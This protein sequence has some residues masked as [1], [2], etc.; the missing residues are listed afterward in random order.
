MGKLLR[1]HYSI[2]GKIVR[3]LLA[4]TAIICLV[5]CITS[6]YLYT[7]SVDREYRLQ[8]YHLATMAALRLDKDEVIQKSNQI[9]DIYDSIPEEERQDATSQAYLD[10]FDGVIDDSFKA[11]C[12]PLLQTQY[13]GGAVS[14]Y[15]AALDMD[16]NRMIFLIDSDPTEGFCP[17]GYYD[18]LTDEMTDSFV[19]G[20]KP[21]WVDK[22]FGSKDSMHAVANAIEPYGFRITGGYKIYQRGHYVI[23]VFLSADMEPVQKLYKEFSLLYALLIL[24]V[25]GIA[26]TFIVLRIRKTVVQPVNKLTDAAMAY[27]KDKEDGAELTRHFHDL[28]I[29][30]GDQ[31][32]NLSLVMKDMEEDIGNYIADVTKATSEK[33]R[34]ATE[35]D[36]A[37]KIQEGM[38]PHTFPPFP[39]RNDIDLYATTDAAKEVGGDF[40][41]FFLLDDD[42]LALVIADVAGKGIPASLFMMASM[43]LI[44]NTA[45][46]NY[47]S[48]A[49]IME[50]VNQSIMSNNDLEMFVT[51]WL[52]ILQLSTGR[53]KAVNA[54]HEYPAIRRA[55]GEFEIYKDPHS[56]V[57]GG[58][59][60]V[61]Y[62]EYELTLAPGDM[63]FQYSDGL[64]E[65]N[66]AEGELFG[67]ERMLQS[68]NRQGNVDPKTLVEAV[69]SD[70][71]EFTKYVPQFDDLTILSVRYNG[72]ITEQ[73]QETKDESEGQGT[74]EGL[75][76][77]LQANKEN[78][79]ALQS[80]VE[81]K[82]EN[83]G[84]SIKEIME[85]GIAI[86]EI[87]V[88]IAEYA[89]APGT[90]EANIQIE[91]DRDSRMFSITFADSGVPYNPLEKKDPDVTL[92]AEARA[93]G[94]LGVYMTKKI[95]DDI[96]YE[97]RDGQNVLT[98]KKEIG[99]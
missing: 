62:H 72:N 31:I 50:E 71:D 78:L 98:L 33:E 28:D 54:G 65:A 84:A 75:E 49:A 51:V 30:T 61:K 85:V 19:Y 39:D 48:P 53:L 60:N 56:F 41:D 40:Y 88:N 94:G 58:M 36:V 17:P 70:V 90:G 67:T 29:H 15:V 34:L 57:V 45:K 68:L 18:P 13:E 5:A 74:M 52:G 77:T 99:R 22:L 42:H 69:K 73:K 11:M 46:Q 27:S 66:N 24:L 6:F 83:F 47:E 79:I 37:G 26:G 80:T 23:M 1:I 38:L 44:K 55:D 81:E 4:L 25:A 76:L 10:K 63:I 3:N 2:E 35:L 96:T 21:S 9:L 7:E 82:L 12:V 97:Y 92:P 91:F 64:T 93:I 89:Y 32:E 95:M 87:F 43:I 16:M 8:T 59:E 14:S 20:D 86:E